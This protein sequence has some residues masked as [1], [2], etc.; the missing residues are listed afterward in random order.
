[1]SAIRT[2]M[3]ASAAQTA[4]GNS[5]AFEIPTANNVMI[6]VDTTAGNTVTAFDLWA[7]V[8]D[9]G[10]TTWYDYPADAVLKVGATTP[11]TAATNQRDIVDGKSTA[12]AEQFIAIF[13]NIASDRI[14]VKWTFTGTSITF[15]VSM[16]AK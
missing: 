11:G 13:R 3:V 2:E 6:G 5:A 12:T 8:S 15:S 1:M 16:V 10:G 7:Q 4:S 14:R 9:D